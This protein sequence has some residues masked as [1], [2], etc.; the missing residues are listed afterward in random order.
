MKRDKS[1]I[2]TWDVALS[3]EIHYFDPELSYELTGY[4]PITED[5]GLDFDPEWFQQAKRVK[6]ETGKYCSFPPGTKKYHDFW[7]E[8]Y[9]KCIALLDQIR[10]KKFINIVQYQ[11]AKFFYFL[12]LLR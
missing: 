11:I 8:E 2:V 4:R 12:T 9:K 1:T 5:K 10:M 3:D 6:L 7:T